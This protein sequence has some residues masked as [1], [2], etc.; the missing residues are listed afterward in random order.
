M[1]PFAGAYGSTFGP[2]GTLTSEGTLTI[3]GQTFTLAGTVTSGDSFGYSTTTDPGV[4]LAT[5][6][7]A[8]WLILHNGGVD[9]KTEADLQKAYESAKAF[10][11][12]DLAAGTGDSEND[13]GR[14]AQHPRA[15][16]ARLRTAEPMGLASLP[17]PE[18][19]VMFTGLEQLDAL[20][21][22]LDGVEPRAGS[23]LLP[24]SSP[25]PRASGP[26]GK[27]GQH[28]VAE[29]EG[30]ADPRSPPSPARPPL[31]RTAPRS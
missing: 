11:G 30:R 12:D 7:M 25:S 19:D 24:P 8:A 6:Q 28:H 26:P 27:L 23:G 31:T 22:R 4:S 20:L 3:D 2:G 5:A 10:R 16:A 15:G 17:S 29:N 13:R 18:G 14:D 21:A 1:N 9:A